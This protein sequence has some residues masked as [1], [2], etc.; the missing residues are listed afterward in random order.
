MSLDRHSDKI[1][2]LV[3][4]L[5]GEDEDFRTVVSE[6]VDSLP[7]RIDELCSAHTKCDWNRLTD[8]AHR[9][10]GAGG[11]YGYPSISTLA[12]NMEQAFRR[13]DSADFA[14]WIQE[15]ESLVN[16][17]ARGLHGGADA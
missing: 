5:L 16:A 10:K 11:S 13:H 15:L 3:S 8:L 12:A 2:I 6:F 9:L 4:E 14:V 17:A 1:D 7:A